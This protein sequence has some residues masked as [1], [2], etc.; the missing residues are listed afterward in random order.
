MAKNNKDIA[1]EA[2]A[3]KKVRNIASSIQANMDNLYKN[4]Y[5]SQPNL[6]NDFNSLNR[7]INN[8]IDQITNKN[9]D[10]VGQ[11]NISKLYSRVI[12]GGKT[13]SGIQGKNVTDQL[14][15]I[16]ENGP[17]MD[18][19][20]SSFMQN[21]YLKELDQEIDAVCKYMPRLLEALDTRKD[22]VLSADHFSKDFLTVTRNQL[23][24]E[25]IFSNRIDDLKEKYNLLTFVEDTYDNAS[26]YGEEF[27]YVI[28][29]KKALAKLLNTKGKTSVSSVTMEATNLTIT[30]NDVDS[31]NP[32]YVR[33]SAHRLVE[34][35]ENKTK[36]VIRESVLSGQERFNMSVEICQSNIIESVVRSRESVNKKM[37]KIN[38]SSLY[39]ETA[40]DPT[41]KSYPN[42][43][44]I[45]GALSFDGV[46]PGK[47]SNITAYDGL[48]GFGNKGIKDDDIKTPGCIIK[49]LEHDQVKPIYID[50]IC[51]GYYY[52][53]FCG[54]EL[55]KDNMYGM[56]NSM[57]DALSSSSAG[58]M[59][60][61]YN[62]IETG[63]QD[64]IISYI[65]GQ[66]SQYI[67][68]S[69]VNA[70]QDLRKEIYM[71]LKHNDIFNTPNLDRIRVTF[72]P[73][74]EMVHVCFRKDPITH[75]GISDL[76]RAL[77]PAKIYCS[78]YITNA[79]AYLTRGQDK[80]VYYIKQTVE[81]NIA[82]SL[83]NAVSQIKQGDFGIR[84]FKSI[85]SVLNITGRFNDYIIPTNAAGEAPIQFEVVPGQTVEIKNELL[86][87]LEEMAV[88]STDVPLELIQ[89][90]QS[91][92]YATHYTMSNIKFLRKAYKRQ[93][94][95]Q[96]FLTQLITKIYNCE[97]NESLQLQVTLPPPMF[98]NVTNTNQI[99]TN[100]KEY[101][102]SMVEMDLGEDAD[103]LLKKIYEQD[104]NE[105]HLGTYIDTKKNKLILDR[106]RIKA[107]IEKEKIDN[108]EE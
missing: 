90:R 43:T 32:T 101:V 72:I 55:D 35:V 22:N 95:Y 51:M 94:Q 5:S 8:N 84:Q 70:N 16:F 33:E 64:E 68:M 81:N 74:D 10:L 52:L 76:D 102:Q 1:N 105:Y 57:G 44:D 20:Y 21:Y 54:T 82:K 46:E 86:D 104:L 14:S 36:T 9:K 11:P 19:L 67:D 79:I 65:S 98:L 107:K 80:R 96:Q 56:N 103:P 29:Y 100:T 47:N 83:L 23:G 61:M 13:I 17:L 69:F 88:N 66:L 37:A 38:E 62:N 24:E 73:P 7:K 53:E 92:D 4:T 48:V 45:H 6:G 41:D 3:N 89:A 75:R 31:K 15:S 106:A 87:L 91:M 49:R 58:R 30:P 63:K 12:D 42:G 34:K 108:P 27:I 26:R 85:N 71:I 97:Y 39:T 77:I 93:G 18:E 99:I 25:S 50:D 59:S 60:N 28:P 78:L 2:K 40:K